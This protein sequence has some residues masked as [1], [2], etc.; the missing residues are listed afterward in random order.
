MG[1]EKGEGEKEEGWG[2]QPL[3]SVLGWTDGLARCPGLV[4]WGR[5]GQSAHVTLQQRPH[6]PPPPLS[7]NR[8]RVTSR[9]GRASYGG[10]QV[11]SRR[12]AVS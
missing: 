9:R 10:R 12:R 8:N 4:S 3:H 6:H 5:A 2:S 1:E 11:E 7:A